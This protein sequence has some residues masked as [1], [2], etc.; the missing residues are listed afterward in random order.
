[1]AISRNRE[2]II[3]APSSMFSIEIPIL[4]LKII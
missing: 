3:C 4:Y 1:M 2:T